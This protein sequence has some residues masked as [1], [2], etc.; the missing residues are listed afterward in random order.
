MPYPTPADVAVIRADPR[1]VLLDIPGLD[2]GYF[3]F[4]TER[5]PFGDR[6][7]QHPTQRGCGEHAGLPCAAPVL[8][9]SRLCCTCIPAQ[10]LNFGQNSGEPWM[11]VMTATAR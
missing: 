7:D 11:L 4:N 5:P 9:A 1:L 2:F 8:R 10:A 6:L 3:A